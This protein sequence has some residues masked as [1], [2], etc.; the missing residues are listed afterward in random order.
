MN[1]K[2]PEEAL[3]LAKRHAMEGN[4]H[5]AKDDLTDE[6]NDEIQRIYQEMYFAMKGKYPSRDIWTADGV[7]IDIIIPEGHNTK[8]ILEAASKKI[9]F[10]LHEDMTWEQAGMLLRRLTKEKS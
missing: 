5:F 8:Q 6:Y 9:G 4:I 10:P 7:S 3:I 1:P 2:T